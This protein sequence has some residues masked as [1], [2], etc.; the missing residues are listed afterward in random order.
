MYLWMTPKSCIDKELQ[1]NIEIYIEK[2]ISL[3]TKLF[4]K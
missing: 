3:D 2:Q 1:K 4:L